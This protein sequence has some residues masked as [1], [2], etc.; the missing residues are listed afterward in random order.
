MYWMLYRPEAAAAGVIE[1]LKKGESA[2]TWLVTDSK[3][4]KDITGDVQKAYDILYSSTVWPKKVDIIYVTII[5]K[6]SY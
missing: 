4:A 5:M 1:V 6:V 2:S 3:P